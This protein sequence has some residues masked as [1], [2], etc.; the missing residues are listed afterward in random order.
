MESAWNSRIIFR[1]N[2]F[3]R[4]ESVSPQ[5]VV[6]N[7]R[8]L[9]KICIALLSANRERVQGER[10]RLGDVSNGVFPACGYDDAES[11]CIN[12]VGRRASETNR[13]DINCD[14]FARA[15]AASAPP[16]FRPFRLLSMPRVGNG[17]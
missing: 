16:A 11:I 14:S 9:A 12:V 2:I 1:E 4:L 17:T 15:R 10:E 7:F 5:K 13:I 6:T 8:K 3:H